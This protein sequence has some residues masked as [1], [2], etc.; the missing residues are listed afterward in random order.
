MPAINA[1]SFTF[2][3][4]TDGAV[5]IDN[6]DTDTQHFPKIEDGFLAQRINPPAVFNICRKHLTFLDEPFI[7]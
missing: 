5:I 7:E 3:V 1:F 4:I 2:A 6:G